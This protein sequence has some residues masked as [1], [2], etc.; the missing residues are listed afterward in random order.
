MGI[1][2][3][4]PGLAR[5]YFLQYLPQNHTTLIVL[6]IA[7]HHILP[8]LFKS[9]LISHTTLHVQLLAVAEACSA[10]PAEA[11][12]QLMACTV[13]SLITLACAA[14]SAHSAAAAMLLSTALMGTSAGIWRHHVGDLPA[15]TDRCG[16]RDGL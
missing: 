5:V 1:V 2:F 6:L 15:F 13:P 16:Q 3:G 11:P 4:R 10:N 8:H 14:P 9:I 7:T 12:L